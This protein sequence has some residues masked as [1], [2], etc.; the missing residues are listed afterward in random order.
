M[1]LT[2]KNLLQYS[3]TGAERLYYI[4][5]SNTVYSTPYLWLYQAKILIKSNP[6]RRGFA[7]SERRQGVLLGQD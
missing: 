2:K 3:V 6:R 5:S 1:H 4:M 7:C